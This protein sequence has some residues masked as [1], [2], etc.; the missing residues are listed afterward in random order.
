[1][2]VLIGAPADFDVKDIAG[3]GVQ[4]I[5]VGSALARSAWGGLDRAARSLLDGSFADLDIAIPSA[6]LDQLFST[7]GR[8]VARSVAEHG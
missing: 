6:D 3:A 7:G 5:S 8:P 4:R 1:V 2:N